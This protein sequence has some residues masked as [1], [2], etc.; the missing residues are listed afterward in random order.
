MHPLTLEQ[1][2]AALH[3]ALATGDPQAILAAEAQVDRLDER[4]PKP[5]LHQVALWYAT[6]GLHVFPLSPGT[7]VPFKGSNGLRDGTT[8]TTQVNHWWTT[9]P[10][11]NIGLATG[12]LFDV[13]DIDG[14]QGV[15]TWADMADEL[16][17]AAGRVSTPR[18]G[19]HHL[20]VKAH[21]GRGNKA[22]IAPGIDY[23]GHGGYV[24]APPSVIHIGPNPGTYTWHQPLNLGQLV[25]A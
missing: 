12:H 9:E 18:P 19:G 8:D 10:Q 5:T 7:K 2:E 1:A 24:V 23:R 13:I 4:K 11:A 14:P 6:N 17:L 21:P 15:M 25:D 3:A 20:Y 16:P 22:S